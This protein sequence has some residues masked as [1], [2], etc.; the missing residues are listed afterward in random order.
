LMCSTSALGK[1]FSEPKSTPIRFIA[2]SP[3]VRLEEVC[4][5]PCL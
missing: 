1:L 5:D 4:P 3:L 2:L